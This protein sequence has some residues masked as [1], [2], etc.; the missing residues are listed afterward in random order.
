[1]SFG[2]IPEKWFVSRYINTEK[3]FAFRIWMSG[4]FIER[5]LRLVNMYY[6]QNK[7]FRFYIFTIR[8]S[9]GIICLTIF[10]IMHNVKSV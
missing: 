10:N 3:W 8:K 2:N 5:T 4:F 6:K 9:Y 1:M 7:N